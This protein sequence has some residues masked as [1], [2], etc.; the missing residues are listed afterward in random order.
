MFDCSGTRGGGGGGIADGDGPDILP[1]AWSLPG[2]PL[3]VLQDASQV[4]KEDHVPRDFLRAD[5][6]TLAADDLRSGTGAGGT[7]GG[8]P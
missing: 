3:M 6:N 2:K 1:P 7:T 4:R 5:L 8:S